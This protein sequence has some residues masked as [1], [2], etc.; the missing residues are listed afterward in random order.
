MEALDRALND[1]RVV[2]LQASV[3]WLPYF[4]E[5]MRFHFNAHNLIVYGRE[6]GDYLVS[7]PV[8]ERAVRCERAALEK[9][10]FARGALASHGAMYFLEGRRRAVSSFRDRSIARSAPNHRW[11][12][13]APLPFVGYP[14]CGRWV[15]GS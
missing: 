15:E 3:Y 10:R 13:A 9:A 12:A 2:G 5:D 6:G 1:G 4:P 11:M 14:G 7:D 8:F